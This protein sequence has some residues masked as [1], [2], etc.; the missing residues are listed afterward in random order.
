[1]PLF[2]LLEKPNF[3]LWGDVTSAKNRVPPPVTSCHLLE[4]PSSLP[5]W[6]DVIYGWSLRQITNKLNQQ[7]LPCDNDIKQSVRASKNGNNLHFSNFL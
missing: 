5:S 4:V 2:I 7:H 6:G 3:G 1:M